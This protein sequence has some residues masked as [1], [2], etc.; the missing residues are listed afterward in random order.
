VVAALNDHLN[1][2]PVKNRIIE[3]EMVIRPK[4]L[5]RFPGLPKSTAVKSIRS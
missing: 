5:P 3:F 2:R 1:N 4:L